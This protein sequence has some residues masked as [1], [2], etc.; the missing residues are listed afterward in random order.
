VK[1][2]SLVVLAAGA[3]AAAAGIGVAMLRGADRLEP[4]PDIWALRL[5]R[6]GGGEIAFADLRG[7]PLLINFWATWCPPCV[8]EMPLLARFARQH[9]QAGW[10]VVGIAVDREQAVRDFIAAKGID[11]PIGLASGE[12]LALSRS[13]GNSAGGLPFSIA[14]DASG[15]ASARK[16]G[17]V[18]EGLL[19][20]WVKQQRVTAR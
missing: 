11:F 14:L 7:K 3:A 17:A 16:L 1:R 20:E 8:E 2:R 18:S 10:Q 19:D 12:G 5:P 6:P 4:S 13:L 15:R 9:K